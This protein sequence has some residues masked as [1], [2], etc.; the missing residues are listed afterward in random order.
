MI[1]DIEDLRKMAQRRLP[2]VIYAYVSNG[3][4]EQETLFR[5]RADLQSFALLPRVLNDVSE[6]SLATELAGT[7]AAFPVALAPVGA[8]G[9]TYVSGEIA[10]ARAAKTRSVPY[11]LSTL[12]IDTLEDIAGVIQGPFWFQL[13]MMKDKGVT[14]ALVQRAKDAGCSALLLS[15]DL[16]VRSQRHAEQKHGLVAPP[17][18]DAANIWDALVH[19]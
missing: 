7:P 19:P 2:A 12:S 8:L 11:C 16:H 15:M 5:N 13:Y 18:I 10:A 17:R 3:G 9:L 6:R 1:T 4:Y 14:E